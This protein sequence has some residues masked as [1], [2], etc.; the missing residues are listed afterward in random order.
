MI[1][2]FFIAIAALI[3]TGTAH[4]EQSIGMIMG[5]RFEYREAEE[6]ILW[7]LNGWYG[8]DL[9]KV[10]F[11]TEGRH[12]DGDLELGEFQLLYRRAISPFFDLQLGARHSWVDDTS[13]NSAV[14]GITGDARYGFEIDASAFL[15]EDGDGLAR[16]EI[17][18][19]ILM[20]QRL[21]LQP[22]I[23][24]NAAFSDV[25]E[26]AVS[27]GIFEFQADLRLRYE[28]SRKFAP[29]VGV[30]HEQLDDFDYSETTFVLGMRFWF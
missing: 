15:T 28:F 16:I 5:D 25:P 8:G 2:R 12:F 11:K 21:V 20:T 19:D 9:N 13:I 29:Y 10:A 24:I 3:S 7:D 22:R 30:S 23:E 26:L 1:R 27:S 18:R 4:A 14:V 17:E 6:S